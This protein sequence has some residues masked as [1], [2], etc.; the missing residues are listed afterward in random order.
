[1]SEKPDFTHE[2]G[3]IL[4]ALAAAYRRGCADTIARLMAGVSAPAVPVAPVIQPDLPLQVNPA[5]LPRRYMPRT[6]T[7]TE[8]E[9][10]RSE[11]LKS[12]PEEI[13]SVLRRSGGAVRIRATLLGLPRL[14]RGTFRRQEDAA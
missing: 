6:W 8:D 13:G 5:P 1:M 10:L 4:D 12:P 7:E 11:W 2:T 9:L 3:V 14:P